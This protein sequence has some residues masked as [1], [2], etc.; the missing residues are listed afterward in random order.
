MSTTFDT[1]V[2]IYAVQVGERRHPAAL[3]LLGRGRPAKV[4]LGLQVFGEFMQAAP[5]RLGIP[6]RDAAEQVV[7]WLQ[8]FPEPFAASEGALRMALTAAAADRFQY[9]DALLLASAAEAGCDALISEDMHPGA[10][11]G[12]IRIVRAFEGNDVS[13]EARALLGHASL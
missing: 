2:L 4:R 8:M 1:N 5:R 3:D 13:P 10:A 6:R 7:R 9:W 12:R 11:L